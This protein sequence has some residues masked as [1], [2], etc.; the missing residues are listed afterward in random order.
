V[1]I[2]INDTRAYH[3][4][5]RAS[6]GWEQTISE[7]L[8]DLNS[9]YFVALEKKETYGNI[10]SRFFEKRDIFQDGRPCNVL[11]VGGGYGSI[12][13][14]LLRCNQNISITMVDISPVF[15]DRQKERTSPFVGRVSFVLS[16]VFDYF[17][18]CG[19]FDLIIA[20]EIIGDLPA[21]VEIPRTALVDFLSG[22]KIEAETTREEVAHL[23]LARK[24]LNEVGPIVDD[25]PEIIH[26][27][28]GALRFIK[29]AIKKARALWISEHSSDYDIPEVMKGVFRDVRQDRWPK[30]VRLF[31][32]DE[33]TIRFGHLKRFLEREE[34]PYECGLF[35]DFL[36]VRT[37]E[38]V[39]RI[40]LTKSIANETHEI[41][42]EFLNHVMEYQWL[43]INRE[44]H[45]PP[46]RW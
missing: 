25:F 18:S 31:G 5:G 45:N 36:G 26:L 28:T 14:D 17:E 1:T 30:K 7:S 40:L 4:G 13:A 43:F 2:S 44:N 20:N 22:E 6:L 9:S 11:E 32:H 34:I 15:L 27:N 42:G 3:R 10:L 39:R 29:S 21:L 35:M 16:D 33:V 23:K 12:A 8:R 37:D 38:E 46:Q 41:I 24:F 19:E